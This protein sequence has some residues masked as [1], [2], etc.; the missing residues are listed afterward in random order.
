VDKDANTNK[1]VGFNRKE[2]GSEA[3]VGTVKHHDCH[4]FLVHGGDCAAVDSSVT[5]SAVV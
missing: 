1:Y 4:A 3:L 2:M 5:H